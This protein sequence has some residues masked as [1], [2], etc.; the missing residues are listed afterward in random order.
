MKNEEGKEKSRCTWL[1]LTGSPLQYCRA[2]LNS[3]FSN[4]RRHT[5]RVSLW[6]SI[7]KMFVLQNKQGWKT[8]QKPMTGA[9]HGSGDK[10]D[11][12]YLTKTVQKS[13]EQWQ[14]NHES[15]PRQCQNNDKTVTKQWQSNA[16]RMTKAR[17]TGSDSRHDATCCPSP[18]PSSTVDWG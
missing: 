5:S 15:T 18:S 14:T 4:N 12:E 7:V 6:T 3:P 9:E 16:K 10:N 13:E 8:G 17:P 11:K 2:S 1:V